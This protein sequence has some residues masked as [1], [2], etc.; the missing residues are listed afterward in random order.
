PSMALLAA[1]RSLNLAPSDIKIKADE[2]VVQ[3]GK[4]R[5]KTDAVAEM[6]PQFYKGSGGKPAF[7]EDSFYDVLTGKIPASKYTHQIVLIGATATGVGVQFPAPGYQ[8]LTPVQLIAHLT[9]SSLSE[10]F[11]VDPGCGSWA[12]R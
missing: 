7:A 8:S 6:Y 9:S 5:V 1:A 11:R 10:H 12:T 4:L 2:S 3:L